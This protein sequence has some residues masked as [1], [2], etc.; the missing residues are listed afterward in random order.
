MAKERIVMGDVETRE[1]TAIEPATFR[2]FS[3]TFSATLTENSLPTK[4]D[5]YVIART[6]TFISDF[7]R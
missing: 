4:F 3:R 1:T 6:F 7:A 2:D 5:F